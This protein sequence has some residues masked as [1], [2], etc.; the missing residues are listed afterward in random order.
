MKNLINAVTMEN[1]KNLE[2]CIKAIQDKEN[3][4]I[5][6]YLTDLRIDQLKKGI[7][8]RDTAEK[9]AIKKAKKEHDAR[10]NKEIEKINFINSASDFKSLTINIEWKKSKMWGNNPRAII[11]GDSYAD[12]GYIGGCGYDKESTAI[13]QALKEC[14]TFMKLLYTVKND[15]ID[16]H[17]HELFGYGSGYGILPYYEGGVGTSCLY[18]I[19]DSIGLQLKHIAGGSNYDVYEIIKK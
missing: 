9:I 14:N 15:N 4:C 19:C 13:S 7:I 8:D 1:G 12:S 2:A 16:K 5:N 10:L 3:Y 17:N 11:T 6:R 18:K